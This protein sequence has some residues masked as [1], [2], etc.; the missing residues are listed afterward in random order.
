[1]LHYELF[2]CIISLTMS[3][4]VSHVF[5]SDN[6]KLE[7]ERKE[8]LHLKHNFTTT[9]LDP[10]LDLNTTGSSTFAFER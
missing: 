8:I 4:L 1:M 6:L 7:V 5:P 2:S 9:L 10:L 3:V